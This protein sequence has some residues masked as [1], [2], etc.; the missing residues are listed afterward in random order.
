MGL[1]P[2]IKACTV[3]LHYVSLPVLK[4]TWFLT[5]ISILIKTQKRAAFKTVD[6]F[7][8]QLGT[9][10]NKLLLHSSHK[11]ATAEFWSSL[12]QGPAQPCQAG[13]PLRAAVAALSQKQEL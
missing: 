12:S 13:S 10:G 8:W 11:A 4:C 2:A 1:L 3:F 7:K 5:I 6:K 9:S